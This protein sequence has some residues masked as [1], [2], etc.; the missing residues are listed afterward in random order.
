MNFW[1]VFCDSIDFNKM[2]DKGLIL[3][4]VSILAV[5]AAIFCAVIFI[6][7]GSNNNTKSG[8]TGKIKI[9]TTLFPL[10]DIAKDI[11]GDKAD[12]ILLLPPGIE[13]HSFEPKPTD[14]VK[15]SEADV[16]IYTGKFMEPWAED[17]IKGVTNN[18][19][20]IV[21]ASEG[22]KMISG[23]FHDADE[24][25]GQS[26][27]HIW[28]DFDNDKKITDNILKG[29]I[30]RD[31]ANANFYIAR[32]EDI[33]S[34][35]TDLDGEYRTA[36]GGCPKKEIFYGGHYAFGYLI[37]RYGLEYFAAQGISPDSEPT[38]KD[39][40]KLT[41]QIKKSG[42][43]YIFYEE[44]SSPKMAEIIAEET[45]AK[46]L[47]LNAGHNMT[48]DDLERGVSFFDIMRENLANLRI[49]LE[50]NK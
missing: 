22:V 48:K 45:G 34:K 32:A 36:L 23:V 12:V 43:K 3:R 24:P 27:P 38:A 15:I 7:G 4:V 6:G 14:V 10:Y 29:F 37:T 18:K 40:I 28:L 42:I 30:A 2:G 17:I 19:I 44:L 46:M 25:A 9:V 20:K 50:C 47:L 33:K 16:F 39:L 21:D 49:G 1:R 26:D 35:F 5:F 13:P 8:Q 41:D 11:S 31:P